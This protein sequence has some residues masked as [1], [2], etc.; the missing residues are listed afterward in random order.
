ML[1]LILLASAFVC[2]VAPAALFCRN[3]RLYREPPAALGE[4]AQVAVLIPARNEQANI[5][6]CV[7]SVLASRDVHVDV[8]VMDDGSTDGTARIVETLADE[9]ARVRL[10][11]A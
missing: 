2:S 3:L 8:L 9:D 1:L 11:H 7:R 4:Q 5:E 6:E 10:L